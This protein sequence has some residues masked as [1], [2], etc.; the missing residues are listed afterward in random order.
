MSAFQYS[1]MNAK[2]GTQKGVIEAESSKHARQLLR[3]QGLFP[4]DV[5]AYRNMKKKA[6]GKSSISVKEL[7]LMTRQLSTLLSAGLPIEEVLA[8]V[9][10]QTEKQRTKT[11]ISAVRSKV[12]EGHALA[13]AFREFPDAFSELYCGTVAAGEKSGHLDM[14]LQRLAD[15]TEQQLA[16]RQ[17]IQH[18]LIYPSVMICVAFGIVGFLLEFVVPKMVAVY[19]NIGQNLPG[20]TAFLI[21]FSEN[22]K[23]YGIYFLILIF[24]MIFLYR[25]MMKKNEKFQKKMHRLYL[26]IPI[27]GNA[28]RVANTARFSRTFA[29]LSSA[30]VA[31]LEAMSIAA[32]LMSNL[33]IRD[34]VIHATSRVREG[35]NIHLALKQTTFFPP[36][37]IHLIAS[38]EAS[39]QLE[40]M[41]E[42]AAN[43]Q[44]NE[45]SRLIETSLALFEPAIILVMGAIVLFIVLAILLPIFQLDQ[46][47][48]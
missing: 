23:S 39:G 40:N 16:M 1:A 33:P 29:I 28:I 6:F 43:N 25:Y 2:G 24:G 41:L 27:M 11:L 44:D 42:R 22:L 17:K 45:I 18:A 46:L 12:L 8:A 19:S 13:A 3:E 26:R 10:E 38:G 30:G 7:A 35:A 34:A 21:S 31:V 4:V 9:A 32:K 20:M 47:T 36:M 37:S 5:K 48:G 14:V 15:F